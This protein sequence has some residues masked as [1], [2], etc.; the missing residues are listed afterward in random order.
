MA[1]KRSAGRPMK[2]QHL[3]PF[4]IA[5]AGCATRPPAA[6]RLTGNVLTP[7]G[8]RNGAIAEGTFV[9]AKTA[10]LDAC[11]RGAAIR[12]DPRKRQLQVTVDRAALEKQPAGW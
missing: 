12:L 9:T 6:W 4:A 5:L 10:P 2:A 7:P 11:P 1:L 8:M 3:I